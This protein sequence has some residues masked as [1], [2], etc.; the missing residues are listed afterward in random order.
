MHKVLILGN[1][2]V[3]KSTL[4]NSL[5]KSNEHTGNFHG[6][7][8]EEKH[9]ILKYNNQEFDIVD[10][11]GMYSLNS[12]SYEEEV[13]KNELLSLNATRVMLADANSL[14][15]NLY[16][17][18]QLDELNLDY[19]LL[20]NNHD[21]FLKHKNKLNINKLKEFNC[22]EII[23]AKKIKL[24]NFLK[25]LKNNKKTSKKSKN[26]NYLLQFIKKIKDKYNLS[27]E[28]IIKA[29]NGINDNLT[30][31]QHSFIKSFLP[32]VIKARYDYIDCILQDVLF[33]NNDFVYGA[34]K[35]DK[36]L[37]KP[38]VM[39]IGFLITFL[40]SIYLI[41]FLIGP[42]LSDALNVIF[43]F[44]I[45]NPFM[46]FLYL[47][48]D[49][50]WLIQFFSSGVFSSVGTILSFLPQVCLLF[51]FLTMLE[52]SGIISRMSYV[53]DDFLSIFGLNG[54]A[55]YIML[56]GFGCNTMSTM[57]A[58]NMSDKNMKIKTALLNPYISCMARLPVLVIIASAFFG[59][60]SY[61]VI[62]GLYLLGITVALILGGIL[63]KTILKTKSNELLLE[64][65]PIRPLD[66]KHIWQVG[67]VNAFDM[68]KRIFVIVLSVGVIVWCLTHTMFNLSY[69]ENMSESILFVLADKFSFIFAPIGLGSAGIICALIVGVMAKELIVSTFSITNNVTSNT[70]LIASLTSATSVISFTLPSAVSFLIFS[71]LYCPCASNLA[72]LKKETTKFYMWFAVISQFTIAYLLS[73]VVYQ[74]MTRGLSIGILI[75]IV[76]FMIMFSLILIAKK[77][78]SK[79]ISCLF[80]KKNC[81]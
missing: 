6:V 73:F 24:E 20:I 35:A 16:L 51:I 17:C 43:Q 63:N 39:T 42:W 60:K 34:S 3:G 9:K 76:I 68:L 50:V 22:C 15:K 57:V 30:D 81:K 55:I 23:N 52:D 27:E 31:E 13:A 33:I 47:I 44:V 38:T 65:A 69:T 4:F 61:F 78:K 70:A 32:E 66:F 18:L 1:P 10:L 40:L 2:N 49:N 62:T 26:N 29:L 11:P 56:L 41:F 74:S 54:K 46:N 28:K 5:T 72:V 77:I 7:T 64:F 14:R 48:T 45:V 19:I 79:K 25:I 37:L 21:Y 80:C 36:F 75:S 71:L 12:F 58:R 53:F 8:V 67:K 59:A